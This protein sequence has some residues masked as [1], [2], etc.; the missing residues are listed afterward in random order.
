MFLWCMN[1]SAIL[2][3]T[4][5]ELINCEQCF[6]THKLQVEIRSGL[7]DYFFFIGFDDFWKNALVLLVMV[8]SQFFVIIITF[9]DEFL[10]FFCY[11]EILSTGND[12]VPQMFS[13]SEMA[14]CF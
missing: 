12:T 8:A 14:V 2:S 1:F 9:Q 7:T 6:V 13:M 5:A 4:S 3:L 11:K 10:P